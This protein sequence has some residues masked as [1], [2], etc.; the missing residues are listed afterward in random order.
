VARPAHLTSV[1]ATPA[2]PILAETAYPESAASARVRIVEMGSHLA[3]S[4]VAVDFQP[5]L[6]SAEYAA[7]RA[8]GARKLVPLA[9]GMARASRRPSGGEGGLTLVHRLRSLLPSTRDQS[10]ID[11]YDFDDALHIAPGERLSGRIKAES[12]R[13][14]AHMR[15]ARLVLAGNPT[16]AD[17]ARAFASR[18]EIVPSCVDPAAQPMRLHRDADTLTLGW[19]GSPS[20]AQYARPL[21]DSIARMI[22][23]G[24]NLRVVMMG[25]EPLLDAAWIEYR[26]WTLAGERSL[27]SE[28]DVG[29]MPLPDN[30]WTRGKCGYKLL[31]YFAAGLPTIASPVG[32]NSRLLAHG[33]GVPASSGSQWARAV[34]LLAEVAVRR[35]MGRAARA[36]VEREYSYAVW[37]PRLAEVLHALVA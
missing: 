7:T 14:V 26:P 6:S 28:I 17:G 29:L 10:T 33:R 18:I 21:L 3:H 13:S 22:A 9:R 37:A 2:L 5:S 27:L 34:D 1:P 23:R 4:G 11:V 19:V 12:T 30:P 15:T 25:T 24:R 20:T 32:I 31:R 36:F 16:L 8:G 35:E